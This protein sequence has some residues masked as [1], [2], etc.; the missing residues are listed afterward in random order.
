MIKQ[1]SPLRLALA[2]AVTLSSATAL[3]EP[4]LTPYSEP[5]VQQIGA[6]S[7]VFKEANGV[8][9]QAEQG[10]LRVHFVKEGVVRVRFAAEREGLDNGTGVMLPREEPALPVALKQAKTQVSL[11][12]ADLTVQIDRRTGALTY[13]DGQGSP[14]LQENQQDPRRIRSIPLT[15]SITG[16]SRVERTIDGDREISEIKGSQTVG[17]ALQVRQ[18]FQWQEGEALYGLGSHEEG[19]LNLRGTMQYLYQHN[20]KVMMPVLLSTQGYGLL[21]DAGSGMRFHDDA[22][23]S[24]V[25]IE[26]AN[27][28]DYY[29]IQGPEFDDII[30][31]LRTLTGKA[32]MLPRYGFGYVQSKQR[33]KTQDELVGIVQEYRERQIPLD[34]IVQDWRYWIDGQWGAFSFDQ[35][36]FP[37][38]SKMV[39]DIHD[40]DARLM[41]SIW[42]NSNRS[43]QADDFKQRGMVLTGGAYD[44]YNP[45]AQDLYWQYLSNGLGKHGI[46]AWWCDSTEPN[47]WDWKWRYEDKGPE[48][49]FK[50]NLRALDRGMG[51]LR[52]NTYSLHHSQGMYDNHLA[53]DKGTRM[54]NLTRSGYPGQ[55]RY[56]TIT[57]N[58]DTS[59]DWQLYADQIPSGLNFTVT[60]S[61]YWTMDV[62]A[63]FVKPDTAWFNEN[64]KFP[65]G[66]DDL[67]YRELY[68]RM[69]QWAAFL[70]VMRSHGADTPREVWRFGEPGTPFYDALTDMLDLRYRLLPYTYSLAGQVYHQDATFSRLLAFDFREDSQTH[71]VKDQYLYGPALMVNPVIE[72][73]YYLPGSEPV[74]DA[75]KTRD[76]Y[77]PEGSQW[78]DFWTGERHDGG[79]TLSADAPIAK[80]PLFVRAG[81]ILPMGPKLQHTGDQPDAA[82]ELRIYLGADGSFQLYEDEGEGLGYQQGAFATV[83]LQ[84]DDSKR[85]LTL[86]ERQG[87]FDGL[88]KQRT[89]NLVLVD[90]TTGI[91]IEEAS[92]VHRSVTYTGK[93]QTIKL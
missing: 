91:G 79:Q 13:L 18:Q 59:A 11:S 41:I 16:K 37:D 33:Y 47:N 14:I 71:D 67:G 4:A 51:Q 3:A 74:K 62:G 61:P 78:Q 84:W 87:T 31:D 19:V 43:P 10:F 5:P 81:S 57:W 53:S 48:Q 52:A 25:Q 89:F 39:A 69:F 82:W 29:F 55:Q 90:K 76:V 73:M 83:D 75:A 44:A 80:L 6:I 64:A 58:G 35:E 36:R 26:A 70:P 20:L 42:P 30:Q 56:G 22:E 88:I 54:L 24:F 17:Q 7:Q 49:R 60:G 34:L 45:E 8:T 15:E 2:V 68:T 77:L 63:Y 21:F 86:G 72:P 23:G 93:V 1:L 27:Q 46:D 40:M 38:P 92:K 32:V 9:L 65:E 50:G 85:T 66:V 12:L 28:L